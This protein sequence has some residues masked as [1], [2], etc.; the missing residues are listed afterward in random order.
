[1]MMADDGA[2]RRLPLA[3]VR[4][5]DLTRLLPGG[6][7]TQLLADWGADVIKLED[8]RGG[9]PARWSQPIVD[10]TSIY[11][12]ALN[13]NKRSLAIDLKVPAGRDALLRLIATADVL[14]ESFRPGVME[15]LGLGPQTL[16]ARFPRLIYCAITGYGQDGPAAQRAGHDLN[17]LGYAG[18]LDMNRA[19]P[20]DAPTLPPT[21]IAD[22]AG[23]ALPA[24]MGIL[25]ALV[26]RAT[27][28]RG[29][30][31]DVSML[32]CSLALQPLAVALALAAGNAPRPGQPQ[33]HGGD[34][35]YGIYA[36]SD[37]RHI[38]LAAL[39]PKFWE[40]FCQLVN[41]PEWIPLHGVTDPARR[42]R[43]RHDLAAL[44]ATRAQAEWLA[45]LADE[46][47][48]VGPVLT[49]DEALADPQI[50]ARGMVRDAE[51]GNE[52]LTQALAPV[53]HLAS[54]APPPRRPPPLLGEHSEEILVE[55][56]LTKSEIA[57]LRKAGVV[58][59][60]TRRGR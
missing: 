57:A 23:G 14:M 15:R 46:D 51:T 27:T 18:L 41:H 4:V 9:D 26:S 58:P 5:L 37:G 10:G 40:R 52:Q 12:L 32:D 48:C 2:A 47:V 56:G 3:G 53:P 8:P 31:V 35:V 20:E 6:Y 16:L 59:A 38:T 39:E 54:A 28:G 29:D 55:A 60:A 7:A 17:Y 25:A 45:L 33:L 50:Q 13:R 36:T 30:M 49:L 24:V 43:L 1:M 44:F 22:L 42:E 34:P 19:A 11:Y 21:Q